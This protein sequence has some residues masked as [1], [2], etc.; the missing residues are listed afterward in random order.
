MCPLRRPPKGVDTLTWRLLSAL[1][2]CHPSQCF[3][4]RMALFD[5]FERA[6]GEDRAIELWA[7]NVPRRISVLVA[8]LDDQPAL[9]L[10][11]LSQPPSGLDQGKTSAQLLAL[12]HHVDFTLGKLLVRRDVRFRLVCALV[13]DHH[14][15]RAILPFRNHTFEVGI[16]ERMVLCPDSQPLICR[17]HGRPFR[18]RPGYQ[19]SVNRQPEIIVQAAGVVFLN[20]KDMPADSTPDASYRLRSFGEF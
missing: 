13:P 20:D 8:V 4:P 6:T 3:F 7:V 14:R 17:I 9:P 15:S 2:R 10:A 12:E 11:R 18:H 19:D 16:F 5:L 1:V